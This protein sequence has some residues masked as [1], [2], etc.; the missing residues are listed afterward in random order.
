MNTPSTDENILM[1]ENDYNVEMWEALERLYRN[2]DFK[3]V[4]VDGYFSN[5][6]KRGVSI[7]AAQHVIQNGLRSQVMETL[8]A[9]SHLQDY[10]FNIESLGNIPPEEDE[11]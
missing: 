4:I 11:D 6:A 1:V 7:L 9:I 5:E 10:F 3:K 8:I 2:E